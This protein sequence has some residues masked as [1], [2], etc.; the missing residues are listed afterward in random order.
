MTFSLND[1]NQLIYATEKDKDGNDVAIVSK[2]K[3]G[4]AKG[5]ASARN[6]M[7]DAVG[8]TTTVDVGLTTGKI[9]SQT[10]QGG[11]NIWL[12]PSQINGFINHTSKG[13]NNMTMG[14]GMTL[15]HEFMQTGIGGN[16]K[17]DKS[18][19]GRTD[20]VEDKMNQ[21]R[22]ELGTDWGQRMSHTP[23]KIQGDKSPGYIPFDERSM[24]DIQSQITPSPYDQW[25]ET[26]Q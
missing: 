13:L 11:T 25:I 21:I 26:S 6:L 14:W 5:S 15:M 2:D 9:G 20:D 23:G 1:K 19:F 4:S 16:L 7:M 22:E 17:G 8:N 24:N 10:P 18:A 12:S 3:K